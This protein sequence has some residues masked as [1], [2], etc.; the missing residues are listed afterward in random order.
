[1]TCRVALSVAG[2]WKSLWNSKLRMAGALITPVERADYDRNIDAL[3][4][5]LS[6]PKFTNAWAQGRAMT[7]EQ[8][9]EYA[10]SDA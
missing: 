1:M 7:L 4:A 5:T 9:I 6:K 3:R 10:I 2:R 8:A